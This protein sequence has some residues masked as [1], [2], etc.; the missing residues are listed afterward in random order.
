MKKVLVTATNFSVYC[1]KAKK[2]FE[3]NGFEVIE[4]PHG[5]PMEYDELIEIVE[6]IDAVVVGVDNWVP[7]ILEKAKNLKVM[8]R[9]GVGV[10]NIDLQKA[11]ELEI[12]VTNAKGMNSNPVA[13]ITIG[14]ILSSVRNMPSF[15]NS[16]RE[17]KWE[18]FMGRDLIGMKVGL[19]GFGDIA[20]RV[21]KKLSG[22]EVEI[23]A[24]DK[25]PDF[26]KATELNVSIVE[27][28]E[29]LKTSD[30]VC[31]H[32][33]SLKET[34]HIMNE[35]TFSLMKEGSYFINTARGALVDEGALY[36]A[37][38]SGKICAAAVDVF[39]NEPVE[40]TNLLLTLKNLFVTPHTGAETYE[41]Y[42]IVG[43][44]CAHAI[45]DVFS[46]KE[47]KNRLV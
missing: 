39:E 3:E 13:E 5:R 31:M 42:E 26:E 41:T 24:Y 46:G 28:E 4:N 6:D 29:L 25:Y 33:P 14:M 7:Q 44:F 10:D 20:Q 1:S 35:E 40:K 17:G 9:F 2:L 38:K 15:N 34:Y 8:S 11:E 27:L 37:L 23:C 36:N 43:L 19:L 30:I 12:I 16:V 45:I 22:F 47:P 21:A 18:R 32:L